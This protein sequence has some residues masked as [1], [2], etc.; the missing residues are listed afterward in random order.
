M[1][2][3]NFFFKSL[4]QTLLFPYLLRTHTFCHPL[5]L[6][7]SLSRSL[8]FVLDLNRLKTWKEDQIV[9]PI[10]RFSRQKR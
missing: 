7:L 5:S 3:I 2:L 1:F 10:L 8:S 9:L 4:K 6:S